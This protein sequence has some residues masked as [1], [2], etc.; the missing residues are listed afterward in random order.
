MDSKKFG[1]INYELK[2]AAGGRSGPRKRASLLCSGSATPRLWLVFILNSAFIIHN[3]QCPAATLVGTGLVGTTGNGLYAPLSLIPQSN[4][5]ILSNGNLAFGVNYTLNLINGGFT[6]TVVAGNYTLRQG[7]YAV[8]LTVPDTTNVLYLTNLLTGGFSAN[9]VYQA[10]PSVYGTKVDSNDLA[11]GFLISKL[12]D[13]PGVTW[14]VTNSGG[15]E[16]VILTDT[17]GGFS[18]VALTN[19]AGLLSTNSTNF[20]QAIGA[21]ISNTFVQEQ[22]GQ[23]S[24]TSINMLAA[25]NALLAGVTT[26]LGGL[27]I[28]NSP[29]AYI[30]MYGG[31]AAC[32]IDFNANGT[33]RFIVIGAD[34]Y[35]SIYDNSNAA[36]AL[37]VDSSDGVHL[38]ADVFAAGTFQGNGGGLTNAAGNGYADSTITNA[39][40]SRLV[41]AGT[42]I[43][44]N[45]QWGGANLSNFWSG[46]GGMYI[47]NVGTGSLVASH[48]LTNSSYG[49]YAFPNLVISND[50]SG[51][52]GGGPGESLTNVTVI[53]SNAPTYWTNS[54][55][56]IL[57]SGSNYISGAG[58]NGSVF[59][60]DTNANF[61]NSG[62]ITTRA[63]SVSSNLAS[64]RCY[65]DG[66]TYT[67]QS[68]L[69]PRSWTG[70]TDN[71]LIWFEGN[72]DCEYRTNVQVA[73]GAGF[74][75]L[76]NHWLSSNSGAVYMH[77]RV[78][79]DTATNHVNGFGAGEYTVAEAGYS[80][81]STNYQNYGALNSINLDFE[82]GVDAGTTVGGQ[83]FAAAQGGF[84]TNSSVIH[85]EITTIHLP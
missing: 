14:S 26:N 21:T 48:Y 24:N 41:A 22:G 18:G 57:F 66:A 2:K 12:L 49:T 20:A 43:S 71:G 77:V 25:T 83:Y 70:L 44:N 35:F 19:W 33:N 52:G 40:N 69:G 5:L 28:T 50:L 60:I 84:A 10:A 61:T 7:P 36:N 55:A 85:Y 74:V 11:A 6:N 9:Y 34:N 67:A 37:S 76:T 79:I 13:T 64:V 29:L 56:A 3:S 8:S 46:F 78:C 27:R 1:I 51:A 75:P 68:Q 16:Q 38:G 39:V 81:A 80:G 45:F 82:S 15:N 63:L 59:L 65:F 42:T 53:F 23:A 4:P 58:T 72:G 73:A 31:A 54:G 32:E 30:Y 62:G 47:T 17:S